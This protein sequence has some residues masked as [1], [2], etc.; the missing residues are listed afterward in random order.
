MKIF[1]HKHASPSLGKQKKQGYDDD[2]IAI[3]N[4]STWKMHGRAFVMKIFP[5]I[6]RE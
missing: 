4:F 1:I 2:A 6:N 3:E 5:F